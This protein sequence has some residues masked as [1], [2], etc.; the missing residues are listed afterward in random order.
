MVRVE[1][2]GGGVSCFGGS[3]EKPPAEAEEKV[4]LEEAQA[5]ATVAALSAGAH[6]DFRTVLAD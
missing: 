6:D 1:D 2:G 3:P 5:L 4:P